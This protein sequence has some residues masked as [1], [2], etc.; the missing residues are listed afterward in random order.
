MKTQLF[1]LFSFVLVVVLLLSGSAW[2]ANAQDDQPPTPRPSQP[3]Q[4]PFPGGVGGRPGEPVQNPDGRWSRLEGARAMVPDHAV[5]PLASGGPDSFGYTWN[6]SE[7]LSWIDA[8]GGTDTGLTGDGADNSTGPITLPFS[9]KYYENTYSQVYIAASGYLGFTNY[10]YWPDQQ[11]PMPSID[12]PNNVIAPFWTVTNLSNSGPAGRV[13]YIS[14]GTAPDRYFTVEWYDVKGGTSS[15]SSGGDETYRFEVVLYENGDILFQYHTMVYND[16][17]YYASIGIEDIEGGGLGYM[18]WNN[19][20]DMLPSSG[21]A[22]R[23][24]RPAPAARVNI[25]PLYQGNFTRPGGIVTFQIPVR[26]TGDLGADV[27]DLTLLSTWPSSLYAADG[28]TLLTDTDSDGVID[29]G[30]VNQGSTANIVAKVQ[31]PGGANVGDALAANVTARSSLNTSKSKT[32]TLQTSIPAPFAQVY[33]DEY[34]GAMSLYLAQPGGQQVKKAAN[35]WYGYEP[36]VAEAPNGNF[37]YVWSKG[38][39]LGSNCNI[40][41]YDIE[42]TLLNKYGETVRAVSKLTDNSGATTST[43]DLYPVVA[44]APDGRIGILWY[45]QLYQYVNNAWQDNYNIFFAVLD[46]SGNVAYGPVNLTNNS[47]W[48]WNTPDVPQ[49]YDPKIAATGDSRF[50]L[51]WQRYNRANNC[52]SNDCSINDIY[53]AVRNTGGVEVKG[54]TQFTNDTIGSS[55]EGYYGPNLTGLTG[56]QALITWYRDSDGDVYYAVLDSGGNVVK[57]KTNLSGAGS[58]SW[59]WGPDAVQLSDGKIIVAWTGDSNIRFAVLDTAYNRTA[60][61]TSL[62]TPA[63]ATGS[64]YVS[65]AAD[66]A[67]HAILTWMDSDWNNRRN[68]YYALVNGSGGILTQ[69]MIFRTSQASTPRI[70]TSYVGYGNTSYSSIA[71]GVDTA[72]WPGSSLA[73]GAPGRSAP[74][75]V[76][77]TNYGQTIATGIVMTAMLGTGLTYLG[78]TSGISPTIVGDLITWNLPDISFLDKRQLVLYVGVPDTAT[79]GTRYAVALALTANETD[80]NAS[81]NTANLE[82]MAALQ[83]YLPLTRR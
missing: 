50:V 49:F 43:Y 53:Y 46:T 82:V 74:I 79:I 76:N 60:G 80:T 65:V 40:Y 10:Y 59:D 54:I 3:H 18:D 51:A 64:D 73:G 58:S 71:T 48:G 19:Y 32:V 22:I 21:E 52:T 44:V 70:E 78:D 13:Y 12:Q 8:T 66:N 14:G 83:V 30:S 36:A 6:D 26:N 2:L 75:G 16:W 42:Y 56:N 69:P 20:W 68:L 1:R 11:D 57:N 41:A 35:N 29:T 24:Y 77:Y 38:R 39:C 17:R 61:P 28:A 47:I 4:P 34:D 72:I 5:V 67:G 25:N 55:W 62:T 27:Y 7:T 37:A 33:Q 81:D 9:F 15:D 45:R 31:A 23:F 63:A